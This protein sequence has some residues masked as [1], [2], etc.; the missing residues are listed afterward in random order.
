MY[1]CMYIYIYICIYKYLT[2]YL[3][4][5]IFF[6]IYMYIHI[7]VNIYRFANGMNDWKRSRNEQLNW[8]AP[9]PVFRPCCSCIDLLYT[10]ACVYVYACACTFISTTSVTIE[11]SEGK[12]TPCG[13]NTLTRCWQFVVVLSTQNKTS[14]KGKN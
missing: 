1:I 11:N 6:Y 8:K 5:N 2:I 9:K 12:A 7:Y 4:F 14:E 10:Y 3:S 13:M